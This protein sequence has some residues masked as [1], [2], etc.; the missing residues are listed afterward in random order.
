MSVELVRLIESIQRDKNVDKHVLFDA[1]RTALTNAARK[2]YPDVEPETI[3]VE[4]NEETG[5]QYQPEQ[6]TSAVI[7]HHPRAKYFVAR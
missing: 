1:I 6:T 3:V 7:C 2:H 4:V 5:W